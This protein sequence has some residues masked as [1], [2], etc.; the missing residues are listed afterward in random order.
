KNNESI[1]DLTHDYNLKPSEIETVIKY[2]DA[3]A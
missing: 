2:F 3:A 1:S